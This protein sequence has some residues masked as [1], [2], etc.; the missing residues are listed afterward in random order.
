ML[1]AASAPVEVSVTNDEAAALV[2]GRSTSKAMVAAWE[3]TL[4]QM[5]MLSRETQKG[6]PSFLRTLTS[7]LKILKAF[8]V[9]SEGESLM[10]STS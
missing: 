10:L 2:E 9:S 4:S 6:D 7:L 5:M 8:N 3:E 1:S